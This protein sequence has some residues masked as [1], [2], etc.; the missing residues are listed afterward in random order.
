[1]RGKSSVEKIGTKRL[2]QDARPIEVLSSLTVVGTE[3]LI[4]ASHFLDRRAYQQYILGIII[5]VYESNF[6]PY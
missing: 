1:M 6:F 3:I 5:Q 2:Y 4:I